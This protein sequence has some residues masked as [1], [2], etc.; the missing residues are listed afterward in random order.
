MCLNSQPTVF[1]VAKG[2]VRTIMTK[3]LSKANAIIGGIQVSASAARLIL[4]Y[5]MEHKGVKYIQTKIVYKWDA[6]SF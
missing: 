4:N 3:V 1:R 2:T 6:P 5:L